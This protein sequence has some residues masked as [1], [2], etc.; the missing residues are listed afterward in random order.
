MALR[1]ESVSVISIHVPRERDDSGRDHRGQPK[2]I[3]IH[4]PRERDDAMPL[5][6]S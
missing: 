5:L 4:V 2:A 6:M 3:S 1:P